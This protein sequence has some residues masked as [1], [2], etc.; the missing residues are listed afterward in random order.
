MW[1][2]S[3]K[4]SSP[5]SRSALVGFTVKYSLY[6]GSS[7]K[8]PT[9]CRDIVIHMFTERAVMQFHYILSQKVTRCL[10][11]IDIEMIF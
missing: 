3:E 5:I 1:R 4:F 10:F 7:A 8:L 11:I 9:I 2:L 6:R